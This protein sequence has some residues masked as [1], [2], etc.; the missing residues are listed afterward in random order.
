MLDCAS[1]R[2][3]TEHHQHQLSG[4]LLNVTHSKRLTSSYV[5][6]FATGHPPSEHHQ[7]HFEKHNVHGLLSL[8]WILQAV[9]HLANCMCISCLAYGSM[10]PSQW[11]L[12]VLDCAS[13]RPHTEH[14]QHQL[15]GL[16][17]NVTHSTRLTSS[18]VLDFAMGPPPSEHHQHQLPASSPNNVSSKSRMCMICLVCFGFCKPMAQRLLVGPPSEHHQHQLPASSPNNV[19]SKSTMCMVC[20]VC[21]GFCKAMAQRLLVNGHC[22]CWT[23]QA[24]AHAQNIIRIRCLGFCSTSSIPKDGRCCNGSPAQ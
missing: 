5:L 1:R 3:H 22:W 2:P 17:L 23:A 18:F 12:L 19:S 8:H 11:T 13:R 6:D 9:D 21:F 16:L 14:H 7:H 20:L 10:S 4:L 24:V 15:S